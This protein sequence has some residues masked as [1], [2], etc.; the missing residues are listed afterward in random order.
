MLAKKKE[1]KKHGV[2]FRIDSWMIF[3]N[4]KSRNRVDVLDGTGQQQKAGFGTP[5]GVEAKWPVMKKLNR[6]IGRNRDGAPPGD[7]Q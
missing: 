5:P 3:K 1:A 4:S 2:L 6:R 7:Q